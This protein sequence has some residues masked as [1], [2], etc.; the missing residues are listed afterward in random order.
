MSKTHSSRSKTQ[1]QLTQRFNVSSQDKEASN[2]PLSASEASKQ[3]LTPI[4]MTCYCALCGA[5]S[6]SPHIASKETDHLA[7]I[8]WLIW[9]RDLH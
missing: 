7:H 5:N 8:L 9:I 2:E 1:Q 4:V 3:P 6:M